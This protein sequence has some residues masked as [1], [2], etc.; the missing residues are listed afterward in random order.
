MDD[1]WGGNDIWW[2]KESKKE[3]EVKQEGGTELSVHVK[4]HLTLT[5]DLQLVQ[6]QDVSSFLI[7]VF[8]FRNQISACE[9]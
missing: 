5:L 9:F 7:H 2:S 6:S 8:S 4:C 3:K 1:K